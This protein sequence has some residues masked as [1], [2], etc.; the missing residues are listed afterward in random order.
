MENA[1]KEIF[2]GRRND[3]PVVMG[4]MQDFSNS[5]RYDN[6]HEHFS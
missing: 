6:F 4:G 3:V 2:T 1:Y 5:L